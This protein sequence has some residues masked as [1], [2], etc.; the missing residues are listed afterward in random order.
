VRAI[1][2]E[3]AYFFCR[4]KSMVKKLI[5]LTQRLLREIEGRNSRHCRSLRYARH[6]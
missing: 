5:E 1:R 6:T 4:A 2:I 3:H